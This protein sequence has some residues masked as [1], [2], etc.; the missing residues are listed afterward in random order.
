MNSL[1]NINA[2][3]IMAGWDTMHM[4]VSSREMLYFR[5]VENEFWKYTIERPIGEI[6]FTF[7]DHTRVRD[8]YEKFQTIE[9]LAKHLLTIIEVNDNE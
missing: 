7:G 8:T 6:Y 4:V 1:E 9:E 3:L 2:S 5:N